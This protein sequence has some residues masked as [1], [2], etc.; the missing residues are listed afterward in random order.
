MRVLTTRW[1]AVCAAAGS[2]ALG[3]SALALTYADRHL[4]PAGL[5][6]WDFSDVFGGVANLAVP[7]VGLVLASRQPANRVGWLFLAAALALGLGGFSAAYGLHALVADPG[8]WPAGRAFAWLSNWVWMIPIAMLAYIFLL[9]PAGRLRSRRWRPAA[10]FVGGACTVA[11]VALLVHATASGQTPSTRPAGTE[12]RSCWPR[13]SS[14]WSPR[15]WSASS[16][17]W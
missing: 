5:R 12:A 10:W 2:V 15:W 11:A 14:R 8:S 13:L 9:F 7:V 6:V 4:I 1:I 3:V 16:Q 17:W